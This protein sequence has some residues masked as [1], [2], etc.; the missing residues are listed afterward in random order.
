MAL[1]GGEARQPQDEGL[2][3]SLLLL[4]RLRAAIKGKNNLP[5]DDIAKDFVS[6]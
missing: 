3:E 2:M 5:F 1:L 4:F 6:M